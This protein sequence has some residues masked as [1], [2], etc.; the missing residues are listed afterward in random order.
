[1]GKELVGI[2]QLVLEVLEVDKEF[3]ILEH[4]S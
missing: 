3:L 2:N 1:V 4:I